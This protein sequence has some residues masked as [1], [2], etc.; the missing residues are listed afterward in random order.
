MPTPDLLLSLPYKGP[1]ID[2]VEEHA[3]SLDGSS[4]QTFKMIFIYV[5]LGLLLSFVAWMAVSMIDFL[6]KVC[7]VLS[8]GETPDLTFIASCLQ[9]ATFV[10]I[11]S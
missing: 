2:F 4:L 8:D 7:L 10:L 6:T 9:S 11:I 3:F 5:G 1:K